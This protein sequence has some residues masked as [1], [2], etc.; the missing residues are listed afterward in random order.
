MG[1]RIWREMCWSGVWTSMGQSCRAGRGLVQRSQFRGVFE[2][3]AGGKGDSFVGF[4]VT[5]G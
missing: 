4:R 2:P 3:G 1:V 5:R